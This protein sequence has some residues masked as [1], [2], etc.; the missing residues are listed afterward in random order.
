MTRR[1]SKAEARAFRERWKLVN[2]REVA[3]LRS[4][5]LDVKL[6]Q[7]NVLLAWA[8]EL[9]WTAV[10]SEGE[11]EVRARWARLRKAHRG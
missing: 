10:L 2:D 8:H 7:F 5:P 3:E 1:I 9:G 11:L 6:Q 4:T